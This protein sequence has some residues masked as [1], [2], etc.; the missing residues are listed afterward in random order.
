MIIE[1]LEVSN[2]R[3][4]S[5]KIFWGPGLNIIY[6]NN[7]Q[8]KTNWLEAIHTLSRTK[9]FR[10]QRLSE[11]IRFGEQ[12]AFIEGQVSVGDD[13]HRD[14]RITLRDNTK[15]IWV[16]GKREQLARYLGMLQVFAFTADQL[17]VVRGVP[18]ARRHFIDRGV[19]SLRP[20]YVQ[21]VS[22]YN[23]VIK[24]KN[25]ILQDASEREARPSETE[26]LIAPWNDQLRR[27]GTE[28]HDARVDYTDRLNAALERT[29]FEPAELQIRYL[30][31]LESK[32]DLSDYEALL[33]QRL[34]LRLPAELASG[35][36]LVGPHRDDLGIHLAGREMRAYG[37]SGQQRSAL[38]LLDLA[39]I[40]VYNSSH[41]DYPIFIV[42]DVDAEL[43]EKRIR[44]L[45]E[46]LEGRTQTFIT[47]SK[48]SHL[49]GFLSRASVQ[50]IV[51]GEAVPQGLSRS[52]FSASANAV[53]AVH[54]TPS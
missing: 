23:K 3:N 49:E 25:R 35:R 24:Q 47:T 40:S 11:S 42:D 54:E 41:N 13:L 19:A 53:E 51:Q 9:S 38:L 30:S 27:L 33:G 45:L 29:L 8:G 18:E 46:Y 34:E 22:D 4:L 5:G 48:R 44:R 6:G 31:S 21:T 37:S 43:D 10:T 32:G 7:G 15:S 1:S 28:I 36:S 20:A 14:L 12:T 2:F 17:E 50:E 16:N 52:A 39:A 26:N